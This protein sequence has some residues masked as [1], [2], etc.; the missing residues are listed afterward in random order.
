VR[1]SLHF[2]GFVDGERI[3]LIT[4]DRS[5]KNGPIEEECGIYEC[6]EF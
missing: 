5:A 1:Y 2:G 3:E 6:F 4:V